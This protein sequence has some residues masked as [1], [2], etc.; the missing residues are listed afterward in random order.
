V[1][2]WLDENIDPDSGY[3]SDRTL[4]EPLEAAPAD[5][6]G[7]LKSAINAS[8][9]IDVMIDTFNNAY[10]RDSASAFWSQTGYKCGVAKVEPGSAYL[11]S[12][13][14]YLTNYYVY[15]FLNSNLEKISV[16]GTSGSFQSNIV[17]VAPDNS[18]YMVVNGGDSDQQIKCLKI[19]NEK[20]VQLIGRMDLAESYGE[21]IDGHYYKT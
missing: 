3:A 15:T 11:V 4:T 5:M 7:E 20:D 19:V 6:V 21:F 9:L 8:P 18:A 17:A 14:G 12:G 13:L 10:Y 16:G 2:T 1:H